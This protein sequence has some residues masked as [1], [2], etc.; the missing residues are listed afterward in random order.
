MELELSKRKKLLVFITI[1]LSTIASMGES[2]PAPVFNAVF[3]AFPENMTIV[4]TIISLPQL[5][6][7]FGSLLATLL[8]KKL[9]AKNILIIG[10]I[11]FAIGGIF[12]AS[13]NNAYYMLIMRIPYGLGIAFANVAAVTL[14]CQIYT[15]EKER[16]SI[17]GYYNAFMAFIG[18]VMGIVAG[19][20]AVIKWQNAYFTY[21]AAIPMI[22]MFILVLPNIKPIK[23]D[24]NDDSREAI[25]EKSSLGKKYWILLIAFMIW[26]M[27]YNMFFVYGSTYIAENNIGNAATAGLVISFSTLGSF[28]FCLVFG[29]VYE[30]I[31]KK[32]LAGLYVAGAMVFLCICLFPSQ[33]VAYIASIS[34]GGL[35]GMSLSY[36]YAYCPTIVPESRVSDAVG[37]ITTLYSVGCFFSPY[38]GTLAMNIL[39]SEKVTPTFG[40]AAAAAILCF[41][42]ELINSRKDTLEKA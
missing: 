28:L 24:D 20:L 11:L 35:Y 36:V 13:I 9:S 14:I 12:G 8:L 42:I 7:I 31:G 21:Y 6:L 22:I 37:F 3:E 32:L 15:D 39:G 17:M 19:N 5:M 41:V 4:N 40:V 27:I 34:I 16:G 2:V 33:I 1:C 30:K 29:K 25:K 26:N 10:G 23:E 38:F 18:F